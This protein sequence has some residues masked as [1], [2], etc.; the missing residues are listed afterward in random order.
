MAANAST[1]L[2]NKAHSQPL[3]VPTASWPATLPSIPLHDCCCI[4]LPGF[5]ATIAASSRVLNP[6]ATLGSA[7]GDSNESGDGQD[8]HRNGDRAPVERYAHG[9][10]HFS[11]SG[12]G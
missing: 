9:V 12:S 1:P 4:R 11:S 6:G 7:T 2:T 8:Q 10:L 5:A 3:L